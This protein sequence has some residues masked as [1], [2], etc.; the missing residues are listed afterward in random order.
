MQKMNGKGYPPM[1][2]NYP[3]GNGMGY[4]Q[5]PQQMPRT[6]FSN[7]MHHNHMQSSS[8]MISTTEKILGQKPCNI[9]V[10]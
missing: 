3:G 10:R 2:M 9:L 1:N 8:S 6:N 4:Q 5:Y 7:V